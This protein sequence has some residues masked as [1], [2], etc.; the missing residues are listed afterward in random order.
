MR[1][2]KEILKITAKMG[3][4]PEVGGNRFSIHRVILT[5]VPWQHSIQPELVISLRAAPHKFRLIWNR[6]GPV[7][8]RR[9]N[10]PH[11]ND[12]SLR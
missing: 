11:K 12:G 4:C 8:R 10:W 5:V 9:L 1:G 2:S 7:L 3:H 6:I